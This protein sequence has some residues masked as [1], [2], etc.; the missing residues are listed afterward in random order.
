MLKNV[1]GPRLSSQTLF[2]F[3]K[4][5]VPITALDSLKVVIYVC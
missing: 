1:C 4:K 2:H 3:H 5:V